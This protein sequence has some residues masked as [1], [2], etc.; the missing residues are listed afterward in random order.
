MCY[1]KPGPRCSYHAKKQLNEAKNRLKDIGFEAGPEIYIKLKEELEA[2]QLDY[3]STPAGMAEMKIKI[4]RKEDSRG[5]IAARLDYCQANRA[6]MLAK[7]KQEDKGDIR[8]HAPVIA[9]ALGESQFET[10]VRCGLASHPKKDE[11][12]KSYNI[13]S[14]KFASSL[15]EEEFAAAYWYTSDG[16]VPINAYIHKKTGTYNEKIDGGHKYPQKKISAAIKALD[17]AF[18]K[19]KLETPIV[20]YRGLNRECFPENTD[21]T[22]GTGK[23]NSGYAQYA[24]NLYKEGSVHTF[25]NYMSTSVDPRKA[26]GFAQTEIIMEIKAKSVVALG[27]VSTF[28]NE[29]EMLVN[30][31]TKFRVVSVQRKVPYDTVYTGTPNEYR[32]LMVVQLEEID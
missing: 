10:G 18:E 24:E 8:N 4:E 11:I 30:R 25:P 1:K 20:V 9:P 7:V 3:D 28:R 31:N 29:R 22:M 32:E 16:F 13:H 15:N 19:N 5:N 17:S 26:H 2:A 14:D 23:H 6:A 21:E 27:G 12:V